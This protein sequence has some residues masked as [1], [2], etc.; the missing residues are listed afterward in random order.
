ML[1]WK[2]TDLV[3][4]GLPVSFRVP[5]RS[6]KQLGFENVLRKLLSKLQLNEHG[7]MRR[8]N[9]LRASYSERTRMR[10][11]CWSSHRDLKA[12][13]DLALQLRG[14]GRAPPSL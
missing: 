14:R 7:G 11:A 3:V 1:P 10:T 13:Q 12:Q 9:V 2:Q 8:D 4:N 5:M 6:S